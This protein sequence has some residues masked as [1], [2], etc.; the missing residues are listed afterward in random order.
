VIGKA[1]ASSAGEQ[2]ARNNLSDWNGQFKVRAQC[3]DLYFS[4]PKVYAFKNSIRS[5]ADML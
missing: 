1:E 2:L 5:L 4:I 3:S